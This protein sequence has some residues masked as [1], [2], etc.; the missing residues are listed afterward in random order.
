MTGL[1]LRGLGP[2]DRGHGRA[3]GALKRPAR[4]HPVPDPTA[5]GTGRARLAQHWKPVIN[6]FAITFGDPYQA[7][8]TDQPNCRKHRWPLESH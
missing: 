4:A 6:A 7:A 5:I 8:E 3:A 2:A 1:P